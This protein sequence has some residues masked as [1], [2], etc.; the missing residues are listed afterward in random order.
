MDFRNY[1]PWDIFALL[2]AA[3][4]LGGLMATIAYVCVV[5]S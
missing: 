1:F 3:F 2:C 5:R 4:A